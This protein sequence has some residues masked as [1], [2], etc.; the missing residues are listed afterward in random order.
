MLVGVIQIAHDTSA[1]QRRAT[2]Q[3]AYQQHCKMEMPL[4][5]RRIG[6]PTRLAVPENTGTHHGKFGTGQKFSN[7]LLSFLPLQRIHLR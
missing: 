5:A 4:Q 2:H 1:Q 7:G 3:V 6:V